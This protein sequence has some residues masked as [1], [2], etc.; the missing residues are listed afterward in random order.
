MHSS[1]NAVSLRIIWE[2]VYN[3][4]KYFMKVWLLC[5]VYFEAYETLLSILSVWL[6]QP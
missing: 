3:S 1:Q 5:V 6:S 4:T 2:A